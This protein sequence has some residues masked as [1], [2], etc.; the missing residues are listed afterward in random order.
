M[1]GLGARDSHVAAPGSSPEGR[2]CSGFPFCA[3]ACRPALLGSPWADLCRSW[4]S[5]GDPDGKPF[6][7]E[8]DLRCVVCE[9]PHRC[10]LVLH[11]GCVDQQGLHVWLPGSVQPR[12]CGCVGVHTAVGSRFKLTGPLLSLKPVEMWKLEASSGFW[13]NL[14]WP[15]RG[16]V[17]ELLLRRAFSQVSLWKQLDP[18]APPHPLCACPVTPTRPPW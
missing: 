9:W 8:V 13:L 4:V 5:R 18:R 17:S 11:R 16:C 14:S 15:G 2:V 7:S 3:H 10:S 1:S 12:V 6:F